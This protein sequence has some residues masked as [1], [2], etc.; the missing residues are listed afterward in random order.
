[1]SDAYINQMFIYRQATQT[2]ISILHYNNL[3]CCGGATW[4]QFI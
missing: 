3:N 4:L 1:M 2:L